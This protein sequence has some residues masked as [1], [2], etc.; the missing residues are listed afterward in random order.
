[1]PCRPPSVA[2]RWL[3][4][5]SNPLVAS[6]SGPGH[7]VPGCEHGRYATRRLPRRPGAPGRA[8]AAAHLA[9]R[10][11]ARDGGARRPDAARRPGSAPWLRRRRERGGSEHDR[12]RDRRAVHRPRPRPV[13]PDARARADHADR[14]RVLGAG[15]DLLLCMAAAHSVPVRRHGPAGVHDRPAGARRARAAGR[16][17]GS[18]LP[19]LDLH[20]GLLRD[21]AGTRRGRADARRVD[22]HPRA[23]RDRDA[24]GRRIA[25][26]SQSAGAR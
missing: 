7:V 8:V 25:A 17:A 1:M 3:L 6:I 21:R 5:Y 23:D 11:G 12:R 19:R 22:D 26:R 10:A 24:R 15:R 16:A 18:V 14:S 4:L 20:R 9:A 13:R 2:I